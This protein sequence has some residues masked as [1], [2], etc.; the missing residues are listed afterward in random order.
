M[1]IQQTAKFLLEVA[2]SK[3][4]GK[5]VK[6]YSCEKW[7]NF[8]SLEEVK[9]GNDVTNQGLIKALQHWVNLKIFRAG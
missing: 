9:F 4:K 2:K 1:L 7:L 3:F 8:E 6:T 5:E